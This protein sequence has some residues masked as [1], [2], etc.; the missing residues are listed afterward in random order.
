MMTSSIHFAT[1]PPF[2]NEPILSYASED[3]SRRILV[4]TLKTMQREPTDIPMYI[5]GKEVRTGNHMQIY[6]PHD[7]KHKLGM[8]H[9]GG[10]KELQS[11]VKAALSA[12]STWSVMNWQARAAI[13]LRA[14]E[15]LAGPYREKINAATMLGQ[16]KNVYQAEI[17]AACELIDFLRFNV[18]ALRR[19][20]ENQ[21][22]SSTKVWNRIE[23]RPL[24]GFVFAITPFNF[25]SIAA[26]LAAAPALMG[27]TIV[28][29]PAY[30]QIYSAQ[31]IMEVF[32]KAGL[33][34]GVI[35]LV[36]VDGPIAGEYIFSHK[37][38]AGLHFTGSTGVFKT[39]WQEIA[40]NIHT[41][42]SYPR[43]VGETGGKDFLVAHSSAEPD[44]LC[45]AI[46]RG[47]FE[48]QGQ[49][50]SALSRLYMPTTLWKTLKPK[51]LDQVSQIKVGD[52]CDFKN[53]VN[54]VITPQSY[55]K[56]THYIE[57]A[58]KD[59]EVSLIF[60]GKHENDKGYFVYPTIFETK[61]PQHRLL[62]EE[63]FG[64]V[65]TVFVYQEK[66]FEEV[67]TLIDQTSPYGLTGAVF[68]QDQVA[69]DRAAVRLRYA[70]GNFYINDKPTGAIVGQ[71]PFGGGR[72]SGT[73][74]KAGADLNLLRWTSPRTIK[75]TFLPPTDFTYPFMQ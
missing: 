3:V 25:T 12:R 55:A 54:A 75:E 18:F 11:A 15:L 16:S 62:C 65:L 46:I 43:I 14:A 4:N 34:P 17:D 29:K 68:A 40:K 23:Y 38:F 9:E 36:Y 10:L 61:N 58:K 13:F 69:I 50:C 39:L 47:A 6:A 53:F 35:N 24:E 57:Q 33:P 45:T 70:A 73:N 52:V 41:Y 48:Y 20:Y 67:L 5:N 2:R 64:P 71:Q 49:K 72:A 27:N 31:V 22:L 63:I 1:A 19:I 32:Q 74:D 51:L 56:I 8:F 59:P 28:W 30:P 7:H 66:D 42:R 37:D 44:A 26:N 21:P 60:G